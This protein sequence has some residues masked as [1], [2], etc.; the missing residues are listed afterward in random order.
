MDSRQQPRRLLLSVWR[1]NIRISPAIPNSTYEELRGWAVRR[2]LRKHYDCINRCRDARA[3]HDRYVAWNQVFSGG[4]ERWR[5]CLGQKRRRRP[6]HRVP[7]DR[8]KGPLGLVRSP[9]W[10]PD[11]KRVAYHRLLGQN[12]PAWQKAWS[13]NP[14]YDLVTTNAMPAFDPSGKRLIATSDNSTLRPNRDLG[15]TW[16]TPCSNRKGAYAIG[17]LVSARRCDSLRTW[18]VFQKS[19][20]GCPSRDD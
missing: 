12:V 6:W 3:D 14:A 17:R 18:P 15:G 16:R 8:K 13:R 7:L 9:S 20:A 4:A 2:S 19:R 10:S 11:G 5:D 1:R